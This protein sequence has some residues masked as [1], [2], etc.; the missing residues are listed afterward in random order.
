[1]TIGRSVVVDPGQ[2]APATWAACPRVSVTGVGPAIADELNGAWRERRPLVVELTPGLGLDD[3]ATPPPEAVTGRQPWEWSA[4][5]D[6]IGERLHHAVWANAVDGRAGADR[7][8]WRWGDM[9]VTLGAAAAATR[10][11]VVLPDGT[12]A[13]CDGGPLDAELPSRIGVAVV[14]RIALEHGSL[15]PLGR[16]DPAGLALAPDQLAA[17]T[18]PRGAARIIAPAGSG[19]TRVLTERARLLLPGWGLPPA[20]VALVA[21]N[22]RAAAEMK[23]RLADLAGVRIRTLN[24][25]GLRLCGDRSTIEEMDVRRLLG[26]PRRPSPAGPRPIPPRRG[27]RPS[28]GC[29]SGCARR[30]GSRQELPDVSDLDRVARRYRADLADRGEVDFD[31]QVVGAI[32]RLLADPAF[33]RRS[34]RFARVLLVDEFQDLTPAHLLLLRLLTGPAGA[35]FGVGDDDQTIYGYAGATPRWLVDFGQLVPRRRP[36]LRW[37]STTAARRPWSTA[38]ANLL[39][40][41][42]LRVPKV[43]RPAPGAGRRPP[44]R[45]LL[46]LDRRRTGPPRAPPTGWPS[47]WTSGA[48]RRARSPCWPGSTPRW[49]RCRCSSATAASRSAAASTPGSS[50]GAACGPPWPGWRWR[51]LRPGAARC[52]AARGG[53]AAQAGHER[54]AARPRGQAAVARR[55]RPAWPGWLE[56]KGSEREAAKVLRPRRRRRRRAQGGRG[57][58]DR[59][60]ARGRAPRDRRRRPRRQR[61]GARR[62]EPRG[63]RRTRRRPRRP[64]RARP[65]RARPGPVSGLA[66]RPARRARPTTAVSPSP[67]STR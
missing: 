1:M 26:Q 14:H 24:A 37:R 22:V 29:A 9:A 47:C 36:A 53:P 11:D 21:F 45:A 35:V 4:D 43:I 31:E 63:R 3:P 30:P 39:T 67:R 27:S 40:R 18:Q 10:A 20:S 15:R 61:R 32:E 41:N 8:R 51:P 55:D 49:P 54:V 56:G 57:G 23:E 65:P 13:L 64:R 5:L 50:S 16:N 38:A 60:R 48:P 42:A 19:K 33:R 46:V 44:R 66:R 59:R 2:E 28:A 58:H 25:L 52:R 6:L 12:A 7:V 62:L 34:Q 17:V